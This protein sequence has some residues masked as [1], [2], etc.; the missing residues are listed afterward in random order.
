V[1]SRFRSVASTLLLAA[2]VALA[3]S[4][5][6]DA[7]TSFTWATKSPNPL[8]RFEAIGGAA[9]GKLYEFA[10]YYTCCSKILATAECDTYDPATDQWTSIAPIPQPISHSGQVVDAD[11]PSNMTFWLAGGFL[12]NDPGPSTTEVWKYS[13]NNNTWTA[14]PPLPAPRGGGV[15]VKIGRELHYYGGSIRT[16]GVWQADY[17]T[18]W[19]LDLDGGTA[20]RTTTTSGQLLAPMPNP[21]NHMGGTELNGK[22][23]A[24]GGQHLGKQDTT[25]QT[26]V[27]VYDPSTNTWSQTTPLPIPTGHITANVFVRN[28]HIVVTAGRG[29]NGVMLANV[30]DYDPSTATW[31]QLPSL[32]SG[33]Q[34]PV[35]GLVGNQIVVTCGF[36]GPLH[37]QTWVSETSAPANGTWQSGPALPIATGEV[38]AGVINN[39]MYLV[40]QD[41]SATMAYNLSTG[42]WR[43]DLAPRPYLGDHHAAEVINNKFY[44]FGGLDG[45]GASAGKVQIYDPATNTWTVGAPAPYAGGSIATALI[46]GKVYIAGGIVGSTTVSTAAV[47]DP[48]TDTWATMASM[49]AGRNHAAAGTDGS[50]LYIFGGRTGGNVPSVGFSDVQIY[51]PATSTWQWSGQSGSTIPPLPQPRGGMGKAAFYNNEFYVMGGETTNAGTGQVAGNVYNRVD[52]YNPVSRTWRLDTPMPTARHGIF[53]VVAN[54]SILVAGGGLHSGHASSTVF[55]IFSSSSGTPT[56]TP[57]PSPSPTP[58]ATPSPTPTPTPTATPTPTPSAQGVSS[59]TLINADTNQPVSGYDPIANGAVIN[60]SSIGT[61]HVN[62]RANTQPSTVGSVRFGLDTNAN[63]RI[64]NSAPYSLFGD[65]NGKYY[66]GSFS[67]GQHSLTGT[68]YSA[69]SAKGTSGTALTISFTVQ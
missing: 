49:P 13:I 3:F 38:S 55:E 64:E 39:V 17:G 10:G 40:G 34:S 58:T 60:T 41:T 53:P 69:A 63:F 68:P 36:N 7:Q 12:G 50:K 32:P 2:G 52:V 47:Y 45:N 11:D 14:G 9:G 22:L 29:Q 1:N 15:L 31:T 8:V 27:D 51:D 6:G 48:A 4:L 21:R 33:R 26:E 20:W 54:G 35:S 19:A 46:G 37:N 62:V 24:I 18:H 16:N 30:L 61:T 67:S 43:S 28:G 23:Y 65:N 44:L 42:T 57:T 66:A 56:P 25:N 5:G 59:F